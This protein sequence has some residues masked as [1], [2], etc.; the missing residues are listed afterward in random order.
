MEDWKRDREVSTERT[1]VGSKGYERC[2]GDYKHVSVG[3]REEGGRE[4]K[5]RGGVC[6]CIEEIYR[7]YT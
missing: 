2:K 6:V 4:R 7:S 5:G 3:R 1:R